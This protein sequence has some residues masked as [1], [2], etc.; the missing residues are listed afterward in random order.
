MNTKNKL[1]LVTGANRGIGLEVCRQLAQKGFKVILTSR[2]PEKGQKALQG[3]QLAKEKIVFYPLDLC[4]EDTLQ[5]LKEFIQKKYGHL[6][7]LVNNAGIFL[8][9]NPNKPESSIFKVPLETFRQTMETNV[10]GPLLLIRAL[11]PLMKPGARIINVASG[12]GQ[13]TEMCGRFPAYR[14]SKTA[15]NALTRIFAYE[16]QDREILVNS[17]CPGWVRTDM[18]GPNATRS[19]EKGADTIV[20]LAL[21]PEKT[22][23]KFFRDQKEL[24]W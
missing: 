5:D 16:L 22:T 13:L 3:L 21:T 12:A 8:D 15:L 10:Y 20:W 23:G 7:V 11:V 17:V 2:N 6:D 19:V 24:S 9:P 18:G 1:A 14:T 4:N